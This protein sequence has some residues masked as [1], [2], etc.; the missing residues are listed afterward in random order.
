M[1]DYERS[2]EGLESALGEIQEPK[3]CRNR[4]ALR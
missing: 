1:S 2:V 4:L 3:G